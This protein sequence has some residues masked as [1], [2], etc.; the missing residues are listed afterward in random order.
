MVAGALTDGL[1]V[2]EPVGLT[3]A[4][5]AD[6][7]G[8]ADPVGVTAA[9]LAGWLDAAGPVDVTAGA[10]QAA[11]SPHAPKAPIASHATLRIDPPPPGAAR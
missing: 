5:L 4:V 6:W 9:V 10:E 8:P 11:S 2:A 7:L 1:G 3:V